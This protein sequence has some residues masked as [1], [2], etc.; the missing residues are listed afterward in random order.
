MKQQRIFPGVILLGFGAYFYLQQAH[1]IL[2]SEFF[3]WPTCS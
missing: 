1:I 2:F 3:T